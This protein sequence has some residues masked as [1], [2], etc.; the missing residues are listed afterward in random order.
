MAVNRFTKSVRR[1]TGSGDPKSA[2]ITETSKSFRMRLLALLILALAFAPFNQGEAKTYQFDYE[3]QVDVGEN[4]SLHVKNLSGN[5]T[6]NAGAPGLDRIIVRSRKIVQAADEDEAE[7]IAG[8]IE[9]KIFTKG[10][11]A[12]IETI[13]GELEDPK[14]SFWD[15][16]IGSGKDW[17]VAVDYD[18]T[19]PKE[20]DVTISSVKGDVFLGG[21]IGAVDISVNSGEIVVKDLLGGLTLETTSGTVDLAD[22]DGDIEITST[23]SDV[24]LASIT[25]AVVMHSGSGKTIGDFIFG[26]VT[27]VQ[28]SGDIE[29]RNLRGDARLKSTSGK[30]VVEQEEGAVDISTHSGAINVS[31]EL[32]SE[33]DFNLET[34]S[35][36][37][38]LLIPRGA[39]GEM[40]ISTLSGDIDT[41]GLPLE[42]DHFS[43]R[44]L[45]GTFG[46]GGPHVTI[47]TDTG[48]I[49]VGW[50]E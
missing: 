2:P 12:I 50:R 34:I 16:L 30:I 14:R 23:T 41:H 39:G 17:F 24:T 22:I 40:T 15:K 29:I 1:Y 27:I 3:K 4:V 7:R 11:Q 21:L 6:I 20:C 38:E 47:R 28:T 37:L 8:K 43:K 42:V 9:L 25:G 44:E 31:T 5:I 48:D 45:R 46:A 36:W 35:G 18:I 32:Y 13:V 33:R 49:R 19:V 26:K 10:K